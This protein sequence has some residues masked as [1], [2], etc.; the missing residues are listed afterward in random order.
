[1]SGAITLIC[2]MFAAFGLGFQRIKRRTRD[3]EVLA[4]CEYV[5]SA[6][7]NITPSL[8]AQEP[9]ISTPLISMPLIS[10]PECPVCL[11][12]RKAHVEAQKRYWARRQRRGR[13]NEA[14][15]DVGR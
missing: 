15:R 2:F 4:L 9:L 10:A 7:R 12:R 3:P 13:E 1:M 11:A 14:G 8:T 5:E 6:V